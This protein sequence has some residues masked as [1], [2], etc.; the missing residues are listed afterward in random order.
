MIRVALAVH[1]ALALAAPALAQ[2]G[3]LRAPRLPGWESATWR[4]PTIPGFRE[5]SGRW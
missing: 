1:A 3:Q 5:D 4:K 2:T